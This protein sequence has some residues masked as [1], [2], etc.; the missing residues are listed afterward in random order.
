MLVENSH[1]P[2]AL[3]EA[4]GT[5]DGLMATGKYARSLSVMLPFVQSGEL[6]L[7]LLERTA[8]CFFEMR[9]YDNAIKVMLHVAENYPEDVA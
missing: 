9:D 6:D 3:T 5:V 2:D 4:F 8:D 1:T 7:G